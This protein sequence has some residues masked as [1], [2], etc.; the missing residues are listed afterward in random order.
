MKNKIGL[1][2]LIVG[3]IL[4]GLGVYKYIGTKGTSTNDNIL[5]NYI[6]EKKIFVNDNNNTFGFIKFIKVGND[7]AVVVKSRTYSLKEET[8]KI[9]N[10]V[11]QY[12]VTINDNKLINNEEKFEIELV[13]DTLKFTNINGGNN[14]IY[15]GIYLLN[16]D[17]KKYIFPK[18]DDGKYSGLYENQ[19]EEKNLLMLNYFTEKDNSKAG[20]YYRDGYN[21]T[22]LSKENNDFIA[23]SGDKMYSSVSKLKNELTGDEFVLGKTIICSFNNN[24]LKFQATEN[25]KNVESIING[26]YNKVNDI[27][28]ID[29]IK[30]IDE[31]ISIK[32]GEYN[33]ITK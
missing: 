30:Q 24:V 14:G 4:I 18:L 27:S 25:G 5:D 16:D 15:E 6:T 19:T 26:S 23:V 13:N 11:M 31:G 20:D 33:R 32:D 8:L 21:I 9:E 10:N 7:Y 12:P 22:Y 17:T 2:L 28:Y 29:L 3:F 1:V